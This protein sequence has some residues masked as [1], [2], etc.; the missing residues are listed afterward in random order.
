MAAVKA[1][2]RMTKVKA[3]KEKGEKAKIDRSVRL[4][5]KGAISRAGKAMESKDLGDL[6]DPDIWIQIDGKHP[7][8]KRRI[9]EQAYQF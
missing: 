9:P 6:Y 1:E 3:R 4:L 5:R 8:K 7:V 2:K